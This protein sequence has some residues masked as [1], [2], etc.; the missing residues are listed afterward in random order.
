MTT[1]LLAA[2]DASGDAH[3]A[4][5]VR[6][7]RELRPDVHCLGLGGP[8]MEKAGVEIVV[9]QRDL[10]V[11]GLLELLPHLGGIA[12]A[13]RGVGTALAASRP[14]LVVLVDSAGFNL[15]LAR[16]SRAG[17]ASVL[18]YVCPQVWAWRSGRVRK[19]ARCVD[20]AAVIFPFETDLYARAGIRADFV[21]HPLVGR[22]R[23]LDLDRSGARAA[24]GLPEDAA[25]VALL[26]ASRRNE[27]RHCLP[28]HLE[29]ARVLHARDARL[30]FVLPLAP[31]L[32]RDEVDARVRR[33]GLPSLLRLDL[34][35]GRSLEAL[36]ACDVALLKPGTATLE[37][38]LLG[39]PAV[40]AGRAHPASAALVR[41]L[42]TVDCMAMPNL[43]AGKRVVPEF[44]QREA[45]PERIASALLALRSGPLRDAQLAELGAVRTRLG[46]GDAAVQTARIAEEMLLARSAT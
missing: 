23:G 43:I 18:Y 25:V 37:A 12:R 20:R 17:G 7:L 9:P 42:V 16:R 1:V 5:L 4:D 13:W 29:V 32:E 45:E 21:G 38:A 14:E 22:L 40:V 31:G 35:E 46:K 11:G 41:R 33:A 19:L 34:V 44:L 39:R 8:A 28:L 36:V 10:A 24:L 6:A 27:L 2:G 26:P 15:P 3:A 30:V